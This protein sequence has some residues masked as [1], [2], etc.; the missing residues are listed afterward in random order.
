MTHNISNF[1]PI[2]QGTP[3]NLTP[4]HTQQN[5]TENFVQMWQRSSSSLGSGADKRVFEGSLRDSEESLNSSIFL[6]QQIPLTSPTRSSPLIH[7]YSPTR[8]ILI[9]PEDERPKTPTVAISLQRHKKNEENK[10][11]L[12]MEVGIIRKCQ[13]LEITGVIKLFDSGITHDE[14]F[15]VTELCRGGTLDAW[16]PK[17]SLPEKMEAIKEIAFTIFQMHENNIVHRDIKP[18]NILLNEGKPVVADFGCA[19]D[20]TDEVCTGSDRGVGTLFYK[21]PGGPTNDSKKHD[22][23]SLGATIFEMLTEEKLAS[24]VLANKSRGGDPIFKFMVQ[25][26]NNDITSAIDARIQD[27]VAQDL[28]KRMLTIN[29][30]ERFCMKQVLEHPFLH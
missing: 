23:F 24:V 14:S 11:P 16:I 2:A 17:A 1:R 29:E 4:T 7:I 5:T 25:T 12:A 30:V 13:D 20:L 27:P 18:Q 9:Y 28:L 10:D 6:A 8:K 26:R 3:L 19:I 15:C 22:V 21:P